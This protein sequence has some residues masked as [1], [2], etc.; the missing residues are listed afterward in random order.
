MV[1]SAA[2]DRA[3]PNPASKRKPGLRLSAD[4]GSVRGLAGFFIPGVLLVLSASLSA[5]TLAGTVKNGTTGK[6]AAGDEVALIR[7]GPDMEEVA[8]TRTDAGGRFRFHLPDA[9]PHLVRAVHQGVSYDREILPGTNAVELQVF[10]VSSDVADISVTADIMRFQAQGSELQ[11]I[12]L[13]AVNNASTPPRT[14]IHGRNFDFFLPDD[15]EIDQGMVMTAGGQPA[16]SPPVRERDKNRY[17]FAVP[18]RPGETQL[19]VV[20]HMRYS[21]ELSVDP[22]P[23]YGAQHFVVMVPKAMQ[24]TPAPG[25][26]FQSMEDPRQADALVRVVSNTRI[27]QPLNFKVFGTGTLKEPGDDSLGAPHPVEDKAASQPARDSRSG[28]GLESPFT[29]SDPLKK[30]HW[31]ILGAFSLLLSAAVVYFISR[32]R[33]ATPGRARTSGRQKPDRT[34]DALGASARSDIVFEQIK[35]ELF[36]LEVKRQR[37]RISPPEYERAR[38]TLD[39]NLERAIKRSPRR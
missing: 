38:A 9:G 12:R 18:L 3:L 33:A 8:R 22:K 10:D 11:G 2:S 15:A 20:F 4:L 23:L 1:V 6:S 25:V 35:G 27:G 31:Y 34:P 37:G 29:A 21:G 5:Q 13:F 32:S 16:N 30:Y 39:R 24:F 17:G 36:Q 14:Q 19:Q 7:P 26:D 28:G